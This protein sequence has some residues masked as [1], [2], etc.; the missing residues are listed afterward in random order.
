[1]DYSIG[2][3]FDVPL[4]SET[5]TWYERVNERYERTCRQPA[6]D[7]VCEPA[8]TLSID[9]TRIMGTTMRGSAQL[10][11]SRVTSLQKSVRSVSVVSLEVFTRN[12]V[13]NNRN[14]CADLSLGLLV[15]IVELGREL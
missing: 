14:E 4:S 13:K 11:T 5:S 12:T 1:M 9:V 3:S 2:L 15:V 10:W 8:H 6:K 7:E